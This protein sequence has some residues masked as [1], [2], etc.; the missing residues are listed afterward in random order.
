MIEMMECE[1]LFAIISQQARYTA[2]NHSTMI[3]SH[4]MLVF[5]RRR[6]GQ[7]FKVTLP[8]LRCPLLRGMDAQSRRTDG[9]GGQHCGQ[10]GACSWL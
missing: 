4:A 9:G 6:H 8:K 2:C 1:A 7:F 5:A 10:G 3:F